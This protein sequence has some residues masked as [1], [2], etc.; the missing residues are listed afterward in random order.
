ME[1]PS[2]LR[3]SSEAIENHDLETWITIDGAR[4]LCRG[5]I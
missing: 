5:G 2:D 3:S 1:S 4:G